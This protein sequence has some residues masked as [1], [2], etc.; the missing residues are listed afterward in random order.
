MHKT[1]LKKNAKCKQYNLYNT[2]TIQ[3]RQYKMHAIQ[4]AQSI[5]H[6]EN[7]AHNAHI[8]HNA[9]NACNT[10]NTLT[11]KITMQNAKNLKIK[12]AQHKI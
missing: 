4:G 8:T 3:C 7:V 11:A 5:M 12:H 10:H 1:H 2:D 6:N 9:L